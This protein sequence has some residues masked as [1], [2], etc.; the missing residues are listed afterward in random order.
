M[1]ALFIMITH[2]DQVKSSQPVRGYELCELI[3]AVVC[4]GEDGSGICNGGAGLPVYV[5][6]VF[7]VLLNQAERRCR[8]TLI[9]RILSRQQRYRRD[10]RTDADAD[11]HGERLPDGE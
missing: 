11:S 7:Q 10:Q 3:S 4:L 5:P 1:E 8:H 6:R 2:A 9:R